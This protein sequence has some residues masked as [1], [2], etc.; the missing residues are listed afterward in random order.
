[1]LSEPLSQEAPIFIDKHGSPGH[2]HEV[3]KYGIHC[4]LN[5]SSHAFTNS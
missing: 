1:M 3:M 4:F 2:I 5:P